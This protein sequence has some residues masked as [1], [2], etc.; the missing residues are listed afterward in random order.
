MPQGIRYWDLL[1]K[2]LIVV[3]IVGACALGTLM[4]LSFAV[5]QEQTAGPGHDHEDLLFPLQGDLW[6]QQQRAY[7]NAHIPKSAYW[8]AQVQKQALAARHLAM[9]RGMS[10]ELA[11]E[12]DPFSGVTWTADG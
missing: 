11:A 9:L 8:R 5:A 4:Y 12:A 3:V 6:F 7:P 2:C 1:L 10:T